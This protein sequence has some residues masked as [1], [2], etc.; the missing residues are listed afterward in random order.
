MQKTICFDKYGQVFQDLVD[1]LLDIIRNIE[2]L[3]LIN[4]MRPK[5]KLSQIT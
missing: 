1:P 3:L 5:P 2:Y 4:Y